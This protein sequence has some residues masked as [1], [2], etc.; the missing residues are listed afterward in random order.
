MEIVSTK[1]IDSSL[2]SVFTNSSPNK[3]DNIVNF[4]L[5]VPS[6]INYTNQVYNLE[7]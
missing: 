5:A 3:N 4:V 1:V 6:E 7:M 2:N